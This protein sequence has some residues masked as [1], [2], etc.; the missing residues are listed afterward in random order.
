MNDTD[1]HT[2][3]TA[4]IT[5]TGLEYETTY[6]V[7]VVANSSDEA[8]YITSDAGTATFTTEAEP[9]NGG[10]EG[11]EDVSGDYITLTNLSYVGDLMNANLLNQFVAKSADENFII[12]F[13]V[14]NNSLRSS[15][16]WIQD[17][18]YTI[19]SANLTFQQ[20][21]AFY[22]N[23]SLTDKKT[24]VINGEVFAEGLGDNSGCTMSVKSEGAG[25]NHEIIFTLNAKQETYQLRFNGTIN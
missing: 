18:E 10:D 11:G 23:M 7:S 8:L 19:N 5:F 15:S 2:V 24:T 22:F 13:S 12:Y 6:S 3:T 16:N 17:G 4:S 25:A 21:A 9:E 1:V 14:S 20:P